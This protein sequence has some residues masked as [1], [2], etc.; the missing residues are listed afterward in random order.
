MPPP[1]RIGS[2]LYKPA[3]SGYPGC[4]PQRW[5]GAR[6]AAEG[7]CKIVAVALGDG[8]EAPHCSSVWDLPRLGGGG[9][10][11]LLLGRL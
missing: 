11:Q 3:A 4:L 7:H 6:L 9:A 5:G 2:L 10:H 1:P 8:G